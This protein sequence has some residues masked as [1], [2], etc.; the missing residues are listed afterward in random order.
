MRLCSL[1]VD[2]D[3]I[4]NY[5]AIHGLAAPVGPGATAVYDRGLDRLESLAAAYGIPLTLFAIGADMRRPASQ[6]R[7]RAMAQS[8]HEIANHTLDHLYDFTRRPLAEIRRQV[9]DGRDRLA[10]ATGQRPTGFRAP[11]Y[12]ITDTVYRLLE[13]AGVTYSSSVFPCPPYYAAKALALAYIGARGRRSHSILDR[14]GVLLAPTAPYRVGSPFWRRGNGL[15]ELPIQ[16]TP[17]LRVHFIGTTLA[18]LGPTGAEWL[19]RMLLGQ[20]FINLE[21]HGID[22]LDVGDGFAELRGHQPDAGISHTRKLETFSR[23]IE[24]LRKH[25]YSFVRLDEAAR[26]WA[27]ALG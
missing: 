18:L 3:E 9:V 5:Y 7:L 8:G 1:S 23:V 24:L 13:E 25:G 16:V 15:L 11:G 4:P 6:S 2:L 27:G 12:T 22:V 20:P 14:P 19:T 26:R 10:A 21:L 17:G